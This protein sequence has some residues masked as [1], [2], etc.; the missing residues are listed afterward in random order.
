MHRRQKPVLSYPVQHTVLSFQLEEFSN[1]ILTVKAAEHSAAFLCKHESIEQR[2][3]GIPSIAN[4]LIRWEPLYILHKHSEKMSFSH[5]SEFL[6]I[7]IYIIPILAKSELMHGLIHII[8]KIFIK[9][10]TEFMVTEQTN[11]LC[12]C[13]EKAF[14]DKKIM[15][16]TWLLICQKD[17]TSFANCCNK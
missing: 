16:N 7:H 17:E 11:V 13:H 3:G 1:H 12:S 4:P 6:V 15:E 10:K 5:L 2:E 9:N 8:H 14:H